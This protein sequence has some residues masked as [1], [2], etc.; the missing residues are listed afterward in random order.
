MVEAG[1]GY[2]IDILALLLATVVIVPTFHALRLGAIL[3]YLA[4]GAILGPWGLALINEVEEIRHLGEFGVIFLLFVLGIELKPDKLWQMRKMVLG[5]GLGQLLITAGIL[6]GI[7]ILMGI[8]Q[9]SRYYYWFW[10]STIID[11]ILP[12]TFVRAWWH[13]N[14]N[15]QNVFFSSIITRFSSGAFVSFGI[16]VSGW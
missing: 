10:L 4:A 11:G 3:G 1:T 16:Y 2:L 9:Q 12:T 14:A 5:L 8:S 7:A 15:G 13:L 6:Y